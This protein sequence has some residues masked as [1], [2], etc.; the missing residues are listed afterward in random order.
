[1]VTAVSAEAGVGVALLA[2]L[3]AAAPAPAW[4]A[5]SSRGVWA[6]CVVTCMP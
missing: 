6:S 3:G 4:P 2:M 1:M 5:R